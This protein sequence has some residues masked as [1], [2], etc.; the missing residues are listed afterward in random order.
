M[1]VQWISKDLEPVTL[2]LPKQT[3]LHL[4]TT[5]DYS[6]PYTV[7]MYPNGRAQTVKATLENGGLNQ[8]IAFSKFSFHRFTT[9]IVFFSKYINISKK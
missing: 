5:K 6:T 9:Y 1:K 8:W 3:S 7:K 2:P 4:L